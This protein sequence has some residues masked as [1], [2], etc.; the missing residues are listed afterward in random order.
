MIS[1]PDALSRKCLGNAVKT[2]RNVI[3]LDKEAKVR[4]SCGLS[5]TELELRSLSSESD[6]PPPLLTP[7]SAPLR[8]KLGLSSNC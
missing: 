2:D 8:R 4:G 5:R 1:R 3:C 7:E 6:I